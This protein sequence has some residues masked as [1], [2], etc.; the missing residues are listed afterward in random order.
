MKKFLIWLMLFALVLTTACKKTEELPETPAPQEQQ[1][2]EQPPSSPP[3]EQQEQPVKPLEGLPEGVTFYDLSAV[4]RPD[5]QAQVY[6]VE[7]HIIAV[8]HEDDLLQV[9]DTENNLIV[10]ERYLEGEHWLERPLHYSGVM[11]EGEQDRVFVAIPEIGDIIQ[12]TPKTEDENSRIID[13]RTVTWEDGTLLLDDQVILQGGPVD[14]ND[15]TTTRRYQFLDQVGVS[16]FLYAITGWEWNEGYGL[17]DVQ[18][19]ENRYLYGTEIGQ[20][21]PWLMRVG[22]GG[23]QALVCSH[24][25]SWYDFAMLDLKSGECKPLPLKWKDE[26]SALHGS[27]TVDWTLQRIAVAE[28]GPE[29][30]RSA[31]V[32]L[33]VYDLADGEEVFAW[34]IP[35][36]NLASD[37][38]KLHLVWENT[39]FVE[40]PQTDGQGLYLVMLPNSQPAPQEPDTEMP[41]E[42]PD[43]DN[44]VN[45]PVGEPAD[46][47]VDEPAEEPVEEPDDESVNEPIDEPVGLVAVGGKGNEDVAAFYPVA[48]RVA[49]TLRHSKTG[50][51]L[52]IWDYVDC[53]SLKEY[54]LDGDGGKLQLLKGLDDTPARLHYHN[55]Q[56]EWTI[57]VD[58]SWEAALTEIRRGDDLYLLGEE[59]IGQLTDSISIGGVVPEALQG[60]V[61]SVYIFDRVLDAHRLVYRWHGGSALDSHYGIYD[62]ETGEK[63][64]VTSLNQQV[65]GHWGEILMLCR[66]SDGKAYDFTVVTLEDYDRQELDIGHQNADRAVDSAVCNTDGSRLCLT[67][68]EGD[69]RIVEVFDTGTQMLLYRWESDA[70][71]EL[72]FTPVGR[73]HLTVERENQVWYVEYG[74]K[75]EAVK[76]MLDIDQMSEEI[77]WKLYNGQGVFFSERRFGITQPDEKGNPVFRVYNTAWEVLGEYRLPGEYSGNRRVYLGGGSAEGPWYLTYN[78]GSQMWSLTVTSDWEITA[79]TLHVSH[80][81]D[82]T[83]EWYMG[84]HLITKV[85]NDILVD[86][87]IVLDGDLRTQAEACPEGL[88][89]GVRMVLDD[90]RFLYVCGA[91]EVDH[92]GIYD[93]STGEDQ[94]IIGKNAI[95]RRLDENY[96]LFYTSAA[97]VENAQAYDFFRMDVTDGE[98]LPLDTGHDGWES[99]AEQ[100]NFNRENTRMCLVAETKDGG[101]LVEV[102]D[103]TDGQQVFQWKYLGAEQALAAFPVGENHVVILPWRSGWRVEY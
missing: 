19:G 11:L 38:I 48:E 40:L 31:Q 45:E 56:Q 37:D 63:Q 84:E 36:E 10:A 9:L 86:G 59:A 55:G 69:R 65:L 102:Y 58:A 44:S 26:A 50:D 21:D 90:H 72:A 85:E 25:N 95:V 98:I 62:H 6:P 81:G 17:Y 78:D 73:N 39:L 32:A 93:H 7:R 97:G 60:G 100:V 82:I 1:Q 43:I 30:Q 76:S 89:Y 99:C 71:Q 20:N 5:E 87:N 34:D 88:G 2:P 79:E 75:P 52:V 12:I 23:S 42:E 68:D 33:R 18:T 67:W 74:V 29:G 47:P 16:R 35:R 13:G 77:Y 101:K 96:L 22:L 27:V 24:W 53:I 8:L 28:T 14:P 54:A 46:E 3:E 92:M 61:G 94:V 80:D 64:S 15:V 91:M 70:E 51:R 41:V 83:G 103:L 4:L 57:T 66:I 49:L